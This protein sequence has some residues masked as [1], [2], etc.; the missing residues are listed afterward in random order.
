MTRQDPLEVKRV[1]NGDH[2][3]ACKCAYA[4]LGALRVHWHLPCPYVDAQERWKTLT[5]EHWVEESIWVRA[6][7]RR[8]LGFR[9]FINEAPRLTNN[10]YPSGDS[11][12]HIR[13]HCTTQV[14]PSAQVNSFRLLLPHE[15]VLNSIASIALKVRVTHATD[16]S[17][18]HDG[19]IAAT[20]KIQQAQHCWG[21]L[22]NQ[23]CYKGIAVWAMLR[24]CT[25]DGLHQQSGYLLS[26]N[27]EVY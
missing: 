26:F 11:Q 23:L 4:H 20:R 3:C 21:V 5:S 24:K 8:S 15:R 25:N 2:I 6:N 1:Q 22:R 12:P 16:V 10:S 19:N 9:V 13:Q 27:C 18:I 7:V 14:C 17:I